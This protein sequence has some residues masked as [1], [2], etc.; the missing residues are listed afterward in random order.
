MFCHENAKFLWLLIQLNLFLKPFILYLIVLLLIMLPFGPMSTIEISKLGEKL[1]LGKALVHVPLFG[2]FCF[3][4]SSPNPWESPLFVGDRFL[5]ARNLSLPLLVPP[6]P[7]FFSW[8]LSV[9]PIWKLPTEYSSLDISEPFKFETPSFGIWIICSKLFPNISR[10]VKS[11]VLSLNISTR[12][13]RSNFKF[14]NL[15]TALMDS[16]MSRIISSKSGAIGL[17]TKFLVV[18]AASS[19]TCSTLGLAENLLLPI[20]ASVHDLSLAAWLID[21]VVLVTLASVLASN[22]SKPLNSTIFFFDGLYWDAL[23]QLPNC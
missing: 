8:W 3:F 17:V 10:V 15:E 4:V 2:A 9:Q 11:D 21:T 23:I 19:L 1:I 13:G 5:F 14:E 7:P 16:S 12:L 22:S 6:F 18:N 20:A